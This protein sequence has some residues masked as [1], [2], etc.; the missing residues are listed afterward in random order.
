MY[1]PWEVKD[2]PAPNLSVYEAM[3]L[4][5]DEYEALKQ[6]FSQPINLAVFGVSTS[7]MHITWQG[8]YYAP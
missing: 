7:D 5:G 2:A 3:N 4:D 6:E 1:P 8:N